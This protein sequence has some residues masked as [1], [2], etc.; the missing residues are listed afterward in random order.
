MEVTRNCNPVSVEKV[1]GC[2][3][4]ILTLRWCLASGLSSGGLL[5]AVRTAEVSL[6]IISVRGCFLQNREATTETRDSSSFDL[7]TNRQLF[8]IRNSNEQQ[9]LEEII[10]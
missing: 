1:K 10:N 4:P 5:K 3:D 2:R 7:L 6:E 9:Q 8:A